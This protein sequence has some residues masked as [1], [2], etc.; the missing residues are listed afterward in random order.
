[1]THDL[2]LRRYIMGYKKIAS[3]KRLQGYFSISFISNST[4]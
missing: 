4:S 2:H 3:L 1:M